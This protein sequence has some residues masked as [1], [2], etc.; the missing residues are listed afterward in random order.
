MDIVIRRSEETLSLDISS[1][2]VVTSIFSLYSK[3][4][5]CAS[6][7]M[8]VS[9]FRP[10]M[11]GGKQFCA[12]KGFLPPGKSKRI[13][14]GFA[15]KK[16]FFFV[17]AWEYSSSPWGMDVAYRRT[18]KSPPGAINPWRQRIPEMHYQASRVSGLG[19]VVSKVLSDFS[20]A[21][22]K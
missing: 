12:A 15:E 1:L 7:N 19:C 2:K 14:I 8:I 21:S 22:G 16:C 6:R 11:C 9:S 20:P 4:H 18:C 17:G 10:E 13:H 3:N 5:S